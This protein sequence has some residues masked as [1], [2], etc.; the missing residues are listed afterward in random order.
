MLIQFQNVIENRTQSLEFLESHV[1]VGKSEIER[2]EEE[3]RQIEEKLVRKRRNLQ[4]VEQRL[5]DFRVEISGL[6][7]KE[8]LLLAAQDRGEEF[9]KT[10]LKSG[11]EELDAM[12]ENG[13]DEAEI[14]S[15]KKMKVESK[16]NEDNF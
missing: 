5:E 1:I 8:K 6:K 2:D 15:R 14:S 3:I 11:K 7:E 9:L 10:L 12:I 16:E 13:M 4:H